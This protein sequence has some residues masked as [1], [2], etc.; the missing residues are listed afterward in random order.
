MNENEI[1]RLKELAK[2]IRLDVLEMTF[3]A[4]A[5]GGHLGGAFSC[6][7]IL[8]ILY[9]KILNVNSKNPFD[10]N[11]DRFI[12]S[13]GHVALA[14]YSILAQSG[15]LTQDDLNSF[16]QNNSDFPTHEVINIE[17][18][19]ETSSG[20][21]GYGL[22]IGVGVALNAKLKNKSYR[23]YVLLGDGE[24]NE[25]SVWE[26]VQSAVKF[27]LDNLTAVIDFNEQ[28]LDGKNIMPIQNLSGVLENFGFEV[29]EC[30]GHDFNELEN[31]LTQN[32]F[33]DRPKIIIAHTLKA[34]GIK[35][36]EGSEGWHHARLNQNDYENFRKELENA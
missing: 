16:E 30:N 20:S 23:T 7:E 35:S 19:I 25:G 14:H 8:A 32:E 4:G 12:L 5:D 11:R 17:K 36:I 33:N 24:C 15:F 34:K 21:L 22:S 1:L 31:A 2:K 6:A 3:K 10:E 28:S 27:K 18:G 9:G 13:K 29:H 26:A